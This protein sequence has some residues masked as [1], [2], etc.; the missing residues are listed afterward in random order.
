MRIRTELKNNGSA[1]HT[2]HTAATIALLDRDGLV[3]LWSEIMNSAAPRGMSQIWLHA[4][5]AFEVQQRSGGG[6]TKAD[7]DRLERISIGKVRVAAPN[8]NAGARF[9]RNGTASPMWSN[10]PP[11]AISGTAKALPPCPLLPEKS[12]A[13]TGRG[14]GSSG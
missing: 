12:L 7:R 5:L 11:R 6:L 13:R 3:V 2:V 8:I 14:Q 10:G 9:L 4:F 1:R